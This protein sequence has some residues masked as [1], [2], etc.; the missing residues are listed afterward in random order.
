M[1]AAD[2]E[3]LAEIVALR[4][5][6]NGRGTIS[7]AAGSDVDFLLDL[8]VQVAR[9]AS[10][11]H[12]ASAWYEDGETDALAILDTIT[13]ESH[14]QPGPNLGALDVLKDGKDWPPKYL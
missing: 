6:P 13:G 5:G 9:T 11:P 8:L 10:A 1:T 14:L 4:N 2:L 7:L 3:K 12:A